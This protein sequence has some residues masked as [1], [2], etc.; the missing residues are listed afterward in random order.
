MQDNLSNKQYK[1]VFEGLWDALVQQ[2]RSIAHHLGLIDAEAQA[3]AGAGNVPNGN[4][5]AA[6]T[7][8][9]ANKVKVCFMLSGVDNSHHKELK[10][11]CGNAYTMGRDELP[12]NTTD[13]LSKMNTY[14]ALQP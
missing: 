7:V 1:E 8:A 11:A 13:L 2:V 6:A 4:D 10:Q 14:R 5:I 9:V 3:I 12:A